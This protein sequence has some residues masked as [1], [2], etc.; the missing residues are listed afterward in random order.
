MGPRM[1]DPADIWGRRPGFQLAPA[2]AA[3]ESAI[4]G[5]KRSWLNAHR[6]NAREADP[7]RTD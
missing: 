5:G 1:M 7:C 6:H 2:G 4:A 3:I